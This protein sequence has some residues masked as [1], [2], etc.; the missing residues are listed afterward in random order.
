M[1]EGVGVLVSEVE[2][3]DIW[4]VYFFDAEKVH[5]SSEEEDRGLEKLGRRTKF[6]IVAM[7]TLREDWAS[8]TYKDAYR[9]SSVE[10]IHSSAVVAGFYQWPDLRWISLLS[11]S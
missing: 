6:E 3:T 7:E 9:A 11:V 8:N 2:E 10:G 5:T 4:T 1:A